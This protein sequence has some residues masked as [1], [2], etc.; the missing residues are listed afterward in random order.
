MR[1]HLLIARALLFVA[2]HSQIPAAALE[3]AGYRPA[4]AQVPSATAKWRA[5]EGR[6]G[7]AAR[8]AV[9]R[10]SDMTKRDGPPACQ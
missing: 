8:E 6:V 4:A 3:A 7:F 10:L 9:R 5:D 2:T 1:T